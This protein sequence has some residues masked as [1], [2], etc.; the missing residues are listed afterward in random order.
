MDKTVFAFILFLCTYC[1]SPKVQEKEITIEDDTDLFILDE[2]PNQNFFWVSE[3]KG[4]FLYK[5]P[6]SSSPHIQHLK[7]RTK[8]YLSDQPEAE[9]SAA[10]TSVKTGTITGYVK[11]SLITKK[12]PEKFHGYKIGPEEE[13]CDSISNSYE[14]YKAIEFVQSARPEVSVKFKRLE[15]EAQF[16]LTRKKFILKDSAP[17]KQ[18]RLLNYFPS[19]RYFLIAVQYY[20]GSSL[21]LMNERNGKT[22]S[23]P[24]FPVISPD[25]KRVVSACY[26]PPYASGYCKN[27]VLVYLFTGPANDLK[28]EFHLNPDDYGVGDPAW[29]SNSEISLGY[30]VFSTKTSEIPEKSVNLRSVKGRWYLKKPK[31]SRKA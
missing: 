31:S 12:F 4:S 3:R 14:C 29:I 26:C 28:K 16:K 20:E 17:Q 6:D 1:A 25:G 15:N 22:F 5:K 8:V 13:L 11:T 27:E 9:N 21:L 18:Y 23:I 30:Y 2:N 10:W 24:D 7:F 19:V